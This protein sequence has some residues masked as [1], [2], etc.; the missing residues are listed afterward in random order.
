M[1][2]IKI[3]LQFIKAFFVDG[4]P[5]NAIINAV[6]SFLSQVVGALG[7]A[8]VKFIVDLL[9][10]IGLS[11]LGNFINALWIGL[12]PTLQF[13][14]NTIIFI[15]NLLTFFQVGISQVNFCCD[16]NPNCTLEPQKR[17]GEQTDP[18]EPVISNGTLYLTMENW[19]RGITQNI[20]TWNV[21]DPCNS[22]MTMY[23]QIPFNSLTKSQSYDVMFC[24]MKQ[25]W[26]YRTD[27]QTVI[28][29][30]SCDVLFEEYTAQNIN[31]ESDLRLNEQLNVMECIESRLIVDSFRM[32]TNLTWIPSDFL[33]NPWRKYVFGSQVL[34]GLSIY[35][36]YFSDRSTNP[37]NL[38]KQEYQQRWINAGL[39]VSYLQNLT[40]VNQVTEMLNETKLEDYFEWNNGTQFEAVKW[41]TLSF[42]ETVGLIISDMMNS[43]VANADIDTSNLTGA[44]L[45]SPGDSSNAL[46]STLF[47]IIYQFLSAAQSIINYWSNPNN[48][49]RY[50][51]ITEKVSKY[52]YNKFQGFIQTLITIY[53]EGFE[54][55]PND[56]FLFENN[57]LKETNPE[58]YLKLKN[59][60]LFRRGSRLNYFYSWYN[61]HFPKIYKRSPDKYFNYINHMKEK[62]P[63]DIDPIYIRKLLINSV[64]KNIRDVISNKTK[65]N[66]M[67]YNLTDIEFN[68]QLTKYEY[69][70]SYIMNDED[71]LKIKQ[72]EQKILKKEDDLTPDDYDKLSYFDKLKTTYYFLT[73]G[74][75]VSHYKLSKIQKLHNH[76]LSLFN[77]VILRTNM[78]L[79]I[80]NMHKLPYDQ[81]K[82]KENNQTFKI[83]NDD[84]EYKAVV[85]DE[86]N[87]DY[88]ITISEPDE[89]KKRTIDAI[90]L[91]QQQQ[92]FINKS[93]F[94][95]TIPAC[96]SNIPGLCQ[97]CYYL[98]QL[99]T[100][101]NSSLHHAIDYYLGPKFQININ[102]SQA[103]LNYTSDPL[104][105]ALVGGTQNCSVRFPSNLHSNLCYFTDRD[106]K[107]GFS[108]VAD[109][110]NGLP[111][112]PDAL[113]VCNNGNVN[114]FISLIICPIFSPVIN[115]FE[116]FFFNLRNTTT[117]ENVVAALFEGIY[118]C[119]W[120]TWDEL[121]GVNKR[122]ALGETGLIFI[123][124]V[125]LFSLGLSALFPSYTGSIFALVFTGTSGV[126]I[127]GGYLIFTYGY[128]IHIF[129][130][131]L[132]FF[133]PFKY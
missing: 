64:Y 17:A 45:T 90:L 39:N 23:S 48:L 44:L 68:I 100:S 66:Y 114:F 101:F 67:L 13:V 89:E 18:L 88:I 9:N 78:K 130:N 82:L 35:F 81:I 105:V 110:I 122:F 6:F 108:D 16:G 92:P 117:A 121:T 73:K 32:K 5:L 8:L 118:L 57:N 61:N 30:S 11:F 56:E 38:L 112:P 59:E 127:F 40:T 77:D 107:I 53:N 47:G 31:F 80:A 104:R 15:L 33:S 55:D 76:V 79:K 131:F 34:R 14:T 102:M 62:M 27:N 25:Y 133:L 70:N 65:V 37:A 119:D 126:L 111:L 24:L 10:R 128:S 43:I 21:S 7:P 98:D 20:M 36:Q 124:S 95:I 84:V 91:N 93:D 120:S 1:L 97:N 63:L 28:M 94:N 3:I 19:I 75:N 72:K 113:S 125:F 60:I 50:A 106:P 96:G 58:E 123:C 46:S 42:W 103:F 86:K 83:P 99:W 29:E 41:L 132:N 26:F 54:L 69:K 87:N 71:E 85:Y 52:T 22:S 49:K 115:F 12:C 109:F 74:S 51:I 116:K 4:E 2:I 129:L